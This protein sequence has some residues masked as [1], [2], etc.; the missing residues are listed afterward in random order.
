MVVSP[1]AH[2]HRRDLPLGKSTPLDPQHP[3]GIETALIDNGR[4]P[5]V[6]STDTKIRVTHRGVR[7]KKPEHQV[8]RRHAMW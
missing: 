5:I 6:E 4:T 8:A 3:D 7:S 1:E 2:Q